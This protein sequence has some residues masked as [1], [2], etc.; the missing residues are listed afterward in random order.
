MKTL[1][2]LR[3]LNVPCFEIECFIDLPKM[4]KQKKKKTPAFV[5]NFSNEFR[6]SFKQS[7]FFEYVKIEH[8]EINKVN[9]KSKRFWE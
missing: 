3:D 9:C 6:T 2:F 4:Q 8:T 5:P 7:I 1:H